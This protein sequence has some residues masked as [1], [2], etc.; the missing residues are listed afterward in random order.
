MTLPLTPELLAA[1]YDFLREAKPFKGWKLPPAEEIGFHVIGAKDYHGVT[2]YDTLDPAGTFIIKVSAAKNGHIAT[3]LA[4]LSH[5]MIHC[6]QVLV[7]DSGNHN[8]MFDR[9]AKQVCRLHGF[10]LKTF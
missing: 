7:G 10:D 3:V 4:T 2:C 9:L 1:G 5:E 8:A 6:R